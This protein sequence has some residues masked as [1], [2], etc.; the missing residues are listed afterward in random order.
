MDMPN[1]LPRDG[2]YAGFARRSVDKAVAAGLT[3]RPLVDTIRDTLAWYDELDDERRTTISQRAG[4]SAEREAEALAAWHEK[5][6]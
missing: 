5:T 3:F 4:L 6:G 1:W 2:D